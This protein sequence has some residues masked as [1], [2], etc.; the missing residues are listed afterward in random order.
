MRVVVEPDEANYVEDGEA[1]DVGEE[2]ERD[3]TEAQQLVSLQLEGSLVIS[4]DV[5]GMVQQHVLEDEV[6]TVSILHNDVRDGHV[7]EELHA[8]DNDLQLRRFLRLSVRA[9]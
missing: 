5:V 1:N 8:R 2:E 9:G 4:R 6:S 3:A 7:H